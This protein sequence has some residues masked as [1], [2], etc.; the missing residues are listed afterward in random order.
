MM[1]ARPSDRLAQ[2]M[3][4]LPGH[5]RMA[6]G[7]VAPDVIT[8]EG[9]GQASLRWHASE[10][11]VEGHLVRMKG[12][13][14]LRMGEEGWRLAETRLLDVEERVAPAATAGHGESAAPSPA[15]RRRG[16]GARKGD[17][18]ETSLH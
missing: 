5:A 8:I 17:G 15:A 3:P 18:G 13:T 4:Y 2:A 12:S 10:A 11:E 14:L 7:L 16:G 1:G 9:G 6:G